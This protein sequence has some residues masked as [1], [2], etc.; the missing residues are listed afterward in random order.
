ME[1]R[2]YTF[3]FNLNR[4]E[5]EDKYGNIPLNEWLPFCKAYTE[6]LDL[7]IQATKDWLLKDGGWEE[8]KDEY[9]D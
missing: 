7:E 2:D 3:T 5:L 8:I 1:N 6:Y 4:D 9:L